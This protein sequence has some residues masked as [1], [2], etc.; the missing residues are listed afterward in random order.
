MFLIIIEFECWDSRKLLWIHWQFW[1]Y[2]AINLEI[3]LVSSLMMILTEINQTNTIKKWQYFI[4]VPVY[5][6]LHSVIFGVFQLF[7]KNEV[8]PRWTPRRNLT[9]IFWVFHWMGIQGPAHKTYIHTNKFSIEN[10]TV[11]VLTKYGGFCSKPILTYAT[12]TPAEK[13]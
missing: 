2:L 10:K 6:M 1:Q 7:A 4:P 9:L 13:L 8:I 11:V 5:C 12:I 3:L